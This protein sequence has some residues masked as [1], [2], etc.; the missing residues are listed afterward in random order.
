MSDAI[1]GFAPAAAL[2]AFMFA[3]VA[4]V[5]FVLRHRRDVTAMK[6]K[7]ATD[8]TERGGAVPFELLLE[9]PRSP[10]YSDLRIGMVLT[11]VGIGAVLFAFTLPK[12]SL[13]GLGLLP[14][15]AGIG[16]LITWKLSHGAAASGKDE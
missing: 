3:P 1:S 10:G 5:F 2:A 6:L 12:H 13:W 8:F 9:R 14:L 4:I 7:A 11:C 16:Y 15:F